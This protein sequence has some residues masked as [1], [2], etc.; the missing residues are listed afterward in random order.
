SAPPSFSQKPPRKIGDPAQA[1]LVRV[2]PPS[3]SNTS[4]SAGRGANL[5]AP[6]YS[7]GSPVG[8]IHGIDGSPNLLPTVQ[9]FLAGLILKLFFGPRRP[10]VGIG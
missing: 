2:S 1:V 10:S 7:G 9:M 6:F 4:P 5:I 3:P 8:R